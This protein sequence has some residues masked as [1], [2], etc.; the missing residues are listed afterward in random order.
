M[1]KLINLLW[2]LSLTESTSLRRKQLRPKH[3]WK[4]KKRRPTRA[5]RKVI[6]P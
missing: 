3:N 4:Q 6:V 5:I 1:K 2:S